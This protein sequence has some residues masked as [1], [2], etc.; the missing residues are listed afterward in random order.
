MATEIPSQA[1]SVGYRFVIFNGK[2]SLWDQRNTVAWV[3][4][5]V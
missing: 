5:A 3:F 4:S 1:G 2:N